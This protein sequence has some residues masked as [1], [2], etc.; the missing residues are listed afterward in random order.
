M[1]IEMLNAGQ[2][3][4][5]WLRT[6]EMEVLSVE[7]VLDL[8]MNARYQGALG[9]ILSEAN[10]SPDFFELE[11]GM[12]GE[13]LQKFS[14]YDMRLAIVGDFNKVSRRSLRDFIYESNKIG[15]INFVGSLDEAIDALS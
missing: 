7:D 11:S 3:Q 5:A 14:T 10:L 12:A 1:E 2:T 4:I 15:R 6:L 8:L 13:I 9:L